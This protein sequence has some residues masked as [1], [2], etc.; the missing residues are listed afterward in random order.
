MYSITAESPDL[1]ESDMCTNVGK[2]FGKTSGSI[3]K[4]M[5]FCASTASATVA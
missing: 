1:S 5:V 3:W 2:P 4:A